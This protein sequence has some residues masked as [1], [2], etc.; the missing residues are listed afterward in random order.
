ML[1]GGV[2]GAFNVTLIIT[3]TQCGMVRCQMSISFTL[4][5]AVITYPNEE[6]CHLAKCALEIC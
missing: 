2:P 4:P 1:D 5:A 6:A 3:E